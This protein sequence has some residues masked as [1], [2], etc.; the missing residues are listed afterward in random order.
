MTY[1]FGQL[2]TVRY[3]FSLRLV[4]PALKACFTGAGAILLRPMPWHAVQRAAI[5]PEGE[6]LWRMRRAPCAFG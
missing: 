2:I 6:Y 1:N 4:A 3:L 5:S